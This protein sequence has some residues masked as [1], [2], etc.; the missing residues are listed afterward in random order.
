MMGSSC[1][2]LLVLISIHICSCNYVS[3]DNFGEQK[4]DNVK[5]H[6][7]NWGVGAPK[8]TL[9]AQNGGSW[10]VE[11]SAG[12]SGGIKSY[13]NSAIFVNRTL[14][15]LKKIDSTFGGKFSTASQGK[16]AFS[17]SYDIWCQNHK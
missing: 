5:V 6:N 13:P 3:S 1:V 11:S 10:C 17:F 14:Q 8:Q 4:F 7:N 16:L 12:D 2:L 9:K 15:S